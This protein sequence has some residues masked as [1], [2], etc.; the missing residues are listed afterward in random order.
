MHDPGS[1]SRDL[2]RYVH[3]MQGLAGIVRAVQQAD[4][5]VTAA[6]DLSRRRTT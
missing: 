1:A 2:G 4:P 6:D 3:P 5:S